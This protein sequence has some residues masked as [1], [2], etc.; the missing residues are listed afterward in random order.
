MTQGT[1]HV[2]D[3]ADLL[4]QWYNI[5]ADLRTPVPPGLRPSTGR[6]IGPQ[7]LVSLLPMALIAQEV[8]QER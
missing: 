2:L 8:N 1:Q 6:P 4:A 5:Q 3:E 7:D